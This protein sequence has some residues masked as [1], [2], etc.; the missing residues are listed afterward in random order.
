MKKKSCPNSLW[1]SHIKL[2]KLEKGRAVQTSWLHQLPQYITA[3]VHYM[4]LSFF[5]F[6]MFM[7][8]SNV[9][10]YSCLILSFISTLHRHCWQR[11]RA[12]WGRPL[13]DTSPNWSGG[14]CAQCR[15]ERIRNTAEYTNLP[16]NGILS[17]A[18]DRFFGRDEQAPARTLECLID[19][20]ATCLLG[21]GES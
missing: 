4:M 10:A 8:C 19:R 1:G 9:R 17:G 2:L 5:S 13:P 3:N 20:D 11:R 12:K 15:M 18:V 7:P 6:L 16:M 14:R 21:T